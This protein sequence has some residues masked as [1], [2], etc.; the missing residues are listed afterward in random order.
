MAEAPSGPLTSRVR[1]PGYK[2]LRDARLVIRRRNARTLTS[3]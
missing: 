2:S 1:G 3:S